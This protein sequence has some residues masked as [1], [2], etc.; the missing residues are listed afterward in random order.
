DFIVGFPGERDRD[1]EATLGLVRDVKYAGAFSFKYSARPG[2]PATAARKHVPDDV[3]DAR[4][5]VLNA[6]L[7]EQQDAFKAS[8]LGR[9][10]DVLFE[11]PGRNPGQIVGRS[12]YLQSVHVEGA[13][14]LIGT[15]RPVCIEGVHPNSLGGRLVSS[16]EKALAH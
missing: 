10:M 13:A 9:T 11:K 15:I 4:L 7:L 8:C 6:L 1:F 12:P 2:T 5:Q 16:R 3:K 14:D